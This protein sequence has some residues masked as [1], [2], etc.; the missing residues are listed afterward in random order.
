MLNDLSELD[1]VTL[2][3]LAQYFGTAVPQLV[4]THE[5]LA[6]EKYRLR[7]AFNCGQRDILDR[8]L[9]AERQQKELQR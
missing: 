1:P 9:Y 2:R 8:I 5:E 7:L 6:D 4:V 3:T